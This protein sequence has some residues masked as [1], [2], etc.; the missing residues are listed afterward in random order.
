MPAPVSANPICE[1]VFSPGRGEHREAVRNIEINM[2]FFRFVWSTEDYGRDTEDLTEEANMSMLASMLPSKI[3]TLQ[4]KLTNLRCNMSP[5]MFPTCPHVKPLVWCGFR[6]IT[7]ALRKIWRK[8][9]QHDRAKV[10]NKCMST[11]GG[12]PYGRPYGLPYGRRV[13]V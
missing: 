2:L 1:H 10:E 11:Y 6:K 9:L 12:R 13:R 5:N 7:E 3:T 8:S 4:R